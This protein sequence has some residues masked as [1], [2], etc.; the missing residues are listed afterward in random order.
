[1]PPNFFRDEIELAQEA[2]N[3]VVAR[4]ALSRFGLPKKEGD[5]EILI[6]NASNPLL[7]ALAKRG[8]SILGTV[9][10]ESFTA[11]LKERLG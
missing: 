9:T 5:K 4:V 11:S 3:R 6:L 7:A 10:L 8:F 2:V 1:M